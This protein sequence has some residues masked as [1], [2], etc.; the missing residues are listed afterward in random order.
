MTPVFEQIQ[1]ALFLSCSVSPIIIHSILH[2]V[3]TIFY[4]CV[5]LRDHASLPYVITGRMHSLCIFI[6]NLSGILLFCILDSSLQKSSTAKA[7]STSQF[8]F[9]IMIF[10]HHLT[11]V[12]VVVNFLDLPSIDVNV[13][14]VNCTIA[15]DFSLSQV[16]I[17]TY[18]FG[19]FMDVLYHLLQL[20]C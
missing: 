2:C 18:W 11:E 12:D 7:Y 19:G 20:W 10:C 9:L 15:H 6:F 13:C 3:V 14:F 16:H 17:E 8:L 4:S 1:L 5:L